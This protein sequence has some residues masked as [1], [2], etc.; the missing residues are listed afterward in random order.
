MARELEKTGRNFGTAAVR[1]E[2][3][4]EKRQV[5]TVL[6]SFEGF[7]KFGKHVFLMIP[8]SFVIFFHNLG[9]IKGVKGN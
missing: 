6:S 4:V 3:K 8:I 5:R 7:T 2:K 1:D 9:N